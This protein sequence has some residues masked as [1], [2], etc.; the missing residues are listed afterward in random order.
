MREQKL[1]YS[2]NGETEYFEIL[3]GVLQGETLAPYLF[4]IVID[5]IMRMAIDG[6]E[7]F[8][9]ILN[10]KR[11]RRYPAAVISDIDYA[12]DIALIC[13]EN[14]SAKKLFNR[15]ESETAKNG[16][17]CKAK[18]T[19]MIRFNEDSI[20]DMKSISGGSIEEVDSF[21][22]LGGWMK[23]CEHDVKAR[24]AQA[25]RACHKLEKI[26]K[27]S[28]SREIKIRLFLVTVESVLLYNSE[29]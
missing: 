28:M 24:K 17:Y 27:P 20:N 2:S 9:F 21:E 16:L 22:Y 8:G 10:P 29:T 3:G 5:Y 11:S 7:Q 25:W 19:K 13:H 4:N 26:W 1:R 18:K 15:V 14:S 12:D 23:C 6:K